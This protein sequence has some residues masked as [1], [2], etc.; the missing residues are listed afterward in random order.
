MIPAETRKFRARYLAIPK[1]PTISPDGASGIADSEAVGV[2]DSQA[3]DD[4][5]LPRFSP[6]NSED[7]PNRISEARAKFHMFLSWAPVGFPTIV[8]PTFAWTSNFPSN[9]LAIRYPA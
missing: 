2:V 3:D 4:A 1:L 6:N 8:Y 7:S 5:V 9:R